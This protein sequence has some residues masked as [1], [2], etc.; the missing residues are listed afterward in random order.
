MPPPGAAP[1]PDPAQSS[2]YSPGRQTCTGPGALAGPCSPHTPT[3]SPLSPRLVTL[4]T[5][6]QTQQPV[7]VRLAIGLGGVRGSAR[8]RCAWHV[9]C[10]NICVVPFQRC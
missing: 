3:P 7:S 9:S 4:T 10:Y 5:P 2:Q 1:A 6:Q 8:D